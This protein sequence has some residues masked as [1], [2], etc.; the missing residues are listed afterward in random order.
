MSSS[1]PP[2]MN[3]TDSWLDSWLACLIALLGWCW[4]YPEVLIGLHWH[5][6]SEFISAGRT[7]AVAHPPGHPLTLL[8]IHIS[9]LF[10]WFDAAERGHLASSLWG[11]LGIGASYLGFLKLTPSLIPQKIARMSALVGALTAIG[12]PMVW[13]Q[14][15][16]A[17][18]YA[19]QWALT[20]VVWSALFHAHRTHDQRAYL[21]AALSLGLLSANHTLLTAALGIALLPHLFTLQLPRRVWGWSLACFA[22]GASLYVYLWLR[23]QAGGISGWGWI[24]S[25]GSLWETISA[26]VWQIQ[27]NQR[28]S[29]V[30]FLDNI[31]RLVA[32]G[33]SQVG[34]LISLALLVSL[35]LGLVTWARTA[36]LSSWI[37]S[38]PARPIKVGDHIE[39]SWG[40]T[41]ALATLLIALTKL[42]YPFSEANP[43]F[44]GYMAAAA[45]GA[46]YLLYLSALSLG[47]WG[48]V[49][50]LSLALTGVISQHPNSRPPQSRGAAQWG[51]AITSEVPLNGSLW[52]SFYAT[53]FVSVGLLIT[54]G[55]RPD[56]HLIFRGHRRLPWAL[57][58]LQSHSRPLTLTTIHETESL[59]LSGARFEV[60]RPIDMTP[61]LWPRLSLP[62]SSSSLFTTYLSPQLAQRSWD[63]SVL[64]E[65]RLKIYKQLL[66]SDA[67]L[68]HHKESSVRRSDAPHYLI[69]DEDSAYSWALHHEMSARWI[70][71]LEHDGDRRS[72]EK[73]RHFHLSLRDMWIKIIAEEKWDSVDFLLT[74]P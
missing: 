45:P 40:P 17:E 67:R 58:R 25:W 54:E 6:T 12:L 44:S 74:P 52:T 50:I 18:V 53:H 33:M 37:S 42:T 26:K 34:A 57:K 11:A 62:G 65:Q 31:I 32:Y 66:L 9:Q 51:R 43:D 48:G 63:I 5:D 24:D 28:A 73:I 19:P 16:R 14:V 72:L 30:S 55:W 20:T 4:V 7:L 3:H 13:L 47:R 15:T 36:P 59:I 29:E 39:R 60:E 71:A 56:L 70:N 8:S 38:A 23:G 27:V 2:N 1:P 21:I 10:P 68:T 46:L 61:Q 69:I 22:G 49:I 35:S 64:E 41:L